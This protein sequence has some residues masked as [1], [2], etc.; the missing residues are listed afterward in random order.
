VIAPIRDLM[1]DG[2]LPAG[3]AFMMNE[4][5]R[6][7][8]LRRSDRHVLPDYYQ[9]KDR[10]ADGRSAPSRGMPVW[11]ELDL[12]WL[13]TLTIYASDQMIVERRL[14]L[15]KDALARHAAAIWEGE[16]VNVGSRPHPEYARNPLW[17]K[18]TSDPPDLDR[19]RI[20]YIGVAPVAPAIAGDISHVYETM[21]ALIVD[22]GFNPFINLRF[23]D[24]RS[25]LFVGSIVYDL[26]E[27]GTDER[28][29]RCYERIIDVL[30]R[31]GY[32]PYRLP[33]FAMQ[34]LPR[35]AD[36]WGSFFADLKAAVDPHDI[37]S[38]GRYDFRY[39][40]PAREI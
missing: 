14:Q 23:W 34:Q 30:G 26:D 28:A 29:I 15:A 25:V 24:A 35:P 40:W 3:S 32:I 37:L 2:V 18:G 19:D 8:T 4:T 20:G 5:R 39:S 27:A 38:P 36:D 11:P 6:Q 9:L 10:I 7:H 22:H 21:R 17:S 12:A 31:D 16:I 33:T 13:C 1:L